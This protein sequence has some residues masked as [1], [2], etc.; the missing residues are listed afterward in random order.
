[1]IL[2]KCPKCGHKYYIICSNCGYEF[3]EEDYNSDISWND[4]IDHNVERMKSK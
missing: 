4:K 1:M 3:K 2:D